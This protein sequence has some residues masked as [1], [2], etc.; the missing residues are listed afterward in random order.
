MSALKDA[1]LNIRMT[2]RERT[3]WDKLPTRGWEGPR[4]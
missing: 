4:K 3:N 1:R 2:P